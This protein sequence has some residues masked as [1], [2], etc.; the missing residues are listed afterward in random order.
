[1]IGVCESVILNFIVIICRVFTEDGWGRWDAKR[2]P[3]I[4]P[5]YWH[6]Y[7]YF[8]VRESPRLICLIL[9]QNLLP[10]VVRTT[11]NAWETIKSSGISTSMSH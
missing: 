3:S 7:S 8:N 6:Y 4:K 1:M 5:S 2:I 10:L 9:Y 11:T